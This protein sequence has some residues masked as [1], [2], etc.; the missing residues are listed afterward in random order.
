MYNQTASSNNNWRHGLRHTRTYNIW[1]QM[2][3]RCHNPNASNYGGY[4][5]RGISVCERWRSF[6]KFFEDMGEAPVGFKGEDMK[7]S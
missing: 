2:L 4:G 7:K 3:Q 5:A 6:P 1:H